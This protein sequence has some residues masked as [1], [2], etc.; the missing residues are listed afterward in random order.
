MNVRI[1]FSGAL[2]CV[3][4]ASAQNPTRI[5]LVPWATDLP[6]ITDIA[7]CGDDRLFAVRQD[8]YI[9]IVMDS[10]SV[11]PAPFLDIHD[12]VLYQGEQGL[13]GLAFDP[14]YAINGYFYVNYVCPTGGT[15]S[16]ISRFSVTN[17]PNVAD[18]ASEEILYTVAQ[19]YVNHKG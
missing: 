15:H 9:S 4:V 14:D 17:D 1:F 18:P 10:M 3:A 7:H 6:H 2:F 13:L 16:R 8:G 11:L 12:S 5:R 19:P